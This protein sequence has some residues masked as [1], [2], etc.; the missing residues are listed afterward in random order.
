M[1]SKLANNKAT[2]EYQGISKTQQGRF[3]YQTKLWC[4][5]YYLPQDGTTQAAIKGVI[6]K[7]CDSQTYSERWL[8]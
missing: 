3:G 4:H 1:N 2:F 8:F 7:H 6:E 5:Q